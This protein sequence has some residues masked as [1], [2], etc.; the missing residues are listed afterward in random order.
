MIEYGCSSSSIKADSVQ[1]NTNVTEGG[2]SLIKFSFNA[3]VTV[4]AQF[5]EGQLHQLQ[6]GK[7]EA[8]VV[9]I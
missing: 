8:T 1:F 9:V 2:F 4:E 6:P 3:N 5:N 7:P